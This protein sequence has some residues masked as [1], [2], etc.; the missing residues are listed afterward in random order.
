AGLAAPAPPRPRPGA[1][2]L[3]LKAE[4]SP[5]QRFADTV[6]VSGGPQIFVMEDLTGA[7]KTEAALI[8]ARRLMAAGAADGVYFALPTMATANAMYERLEKLLPKLFAEDASPS[9]ALLH[10]KTALRQ[11]LER[12]DRAARDVGEDAAK[13]GTASQ[14][15]TAWLCDDRRKAFWADIGAGTIDQALL[16]V[17]PARFQSLRLAGL[18]RKV[19]I[20]DEA[21]AYEDYTL[22]ILNRLLAF[23]A[24]LG[25]SAIVLSATLPS[26][27]R[28]GLIMEF[29]KTQTPNDTSLGEPMA[30]GY[31]L[32]SSWS[33]ATG[34]RQIEIESAERSRRTLMVEHVPDQAAALRLV[35]D[36]ARAGKRVCRLVNTVDDAIEAFDALRQ[37]VGDAVHVDLF[38]ARF[39]FCDRLD[40]ESACLSDFGKVRKPEGQ[41]RILVATQVVEQSLD[42]DFD[43]M[44]TDL[45]PI[46]ALIQRA[47]RVWRHEREGRKG[48]PVLHVAMPEPEL[49]AKANWYGAMLPRA[50]YV[51]A[52][53]AQLW[54]TAWLLRDR[55]VLNFPEDARR[56]VEAVYGEEFPVSAPEQLMASATKDEGKAKAERSIGNM[57]GLMHSYGF[58]SGA[59]WEDEAEIL[60]RLGEKQKT[61]RLAKWN[62]E[63]LRPWADHHDEWLAWRLSEI[64]IPLRKVQ[65]QTDDTPALTRAKEAAR[66]AW[67]DRDYGPEILAFRSAG[68]DEWELPQKDDKT[69]GGIG[70]SSSRGLVFKRSAET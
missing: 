29:K 46:D 2:M 66:A 64:A 26:K 52:N 65:A 58:T 51:Y 1:D 7:G 4:L 70:Y 13:G 40:K 19:L 69:L 31:P 67:P 5:L 59:A 53:H 56:L 63:V 62:G 36:A 49:D 3:P 16:A 17:L 24:A 43:V 33:P 32:A 42:L 8:L 68:T 38:H 30:H 48:T 60:T 47:G 37:T 9:L 44:V 61:W 22:G 11:A 45:A 55:P 10:G 25:G 28:E 27:Q 57:A 6:D 41:G 15:M 39:A 18:A 14:N 23:H 54:R 50:A 34:L 20:V 21:H 12:A 35:A